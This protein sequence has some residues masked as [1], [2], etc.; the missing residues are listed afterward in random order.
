MIDKEPFFGQFLK[1]PIIRI[2]AMYLV[3]SWVLLQFGEIMIDFMELPSVVGRALIVL[4]ALGFP[5]VMILAWVFNKTL[6]ETKESDDRNENPEQKNKTIDRAIYFGIFLAIS[7]SFYAYQRT[8]EE[9][10]ISSTLYSE[11]SEPLKKLENERAGK[12]NDQYILVG[13]LVDFTGS[14]GQSGQSYGQAII[15]ST[16]WINENGGINGKLIDLDTIETSYLVR[17][18]IDAY[19]KWKLQ[20]V[21]AIQAWGTHIGIALRND[22]TDDRV[23]FFSASY[24]AEFTDPLGTNTGKPT[25]YNFFYSPSYS[26]GCRG[27]LEW[28]MSDWK[29]KNRNDHPVFLYMGDNNPYANAPKEACEN[30]AKEIGFESLP[31]LY[32]SM[33]PQDYSRQCLELE[34]FK[35][36]YVFLA[37]L[38][39][40]V[41]SLLSQCQS[42]QDKIQFMVN[43]YGFDESV[44]QSAGLAANGVVW[45]VASASWEDSYAGMYT[46][47]EVSKMSDP[48]NSKYRTLH[49]VRGVC[50]MF[51]LKEAILQADLEGQ[52]SGNK[53]KKAM[54][55]DKE[56]VPEELDGVCLPSNWSETDHRGTNTVLVYQA[57]VDENFERDSLKALFDNNVV[58][59]RQVF[60]A[61]ISRRSEWLGY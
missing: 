16:N 27:L 43:I 6:D 3:A 28:A 11:S 31:S 53:I 13:N 35:P 47:R 15:D 36:D 19:K 39:K 55:R 18:A 42:K 21:S 33:I 41:A 20:G 17:R 14:T 10:Q 51:F 37:N 32:F 1:R 40:S 5:F 38:D 45:V 57:F 54:Y 9:E 8:S 49:Y 12:A 29:E 44:I 34:R 48:E 58:E 23:P 7:I 24:S 52:L 59:I 26:D 60:R 22:V 56:W 4:L 30:Y 2:G 50:S 61:E 46:V 25:P